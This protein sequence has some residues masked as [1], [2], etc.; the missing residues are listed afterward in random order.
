MVPPLPLRPLI[1]RPCV[2]VCEHRAWN[3]TGRQV[4]TRR[5][6][7]PM[8][9][10]A[11]RATLHK[12]IRQKW[13]PMV[14]ATAREH[15]HAVVVTWSDVSQRVLLASSSLDCRHRRSR[16]VAARRG[17]PLRLCASGSLPR[18]RCPHSPAGGAFHAP[19]KCATL[20]PPHQASNCDAQKSLS[21]RDRRPQAKRAASSHAYL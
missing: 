21:A 16:L 11:L 15:L 13:L 7:E 2:C 4:Q 5:L 19:H 12:K 17:M 10:P 9:W 6:C 20:D 1:G 14:A 18:R 3:S 8:G